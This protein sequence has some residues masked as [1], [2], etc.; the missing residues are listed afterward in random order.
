MDSQ[1]AKA[2]IFA[3]LDVDGDGAISRE[4]YLTRPDRAAAASGR[5]SD[6]PLVA[7]ARSA[8][9]R[10]YA[11]MD[12]NGDGRVTF[13]EYAAW[14]GA[15]SFEKVCRPALGSLFDLADTDADGSLDR[16]EFTRLREALGNPADNAGAAFDA[17]DADGDG[18]VDRDAYLASIRAYVTEGA[19]GMAE[20]LHTA[21]SR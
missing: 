7:V 8:H 9:E 10:V 6:D 15:E 3:M 18:R 11:S 20:A 13:E 1:I 16:G 21:N 19:S 12:A 4:E 2:H 14:A 17:L 5:G